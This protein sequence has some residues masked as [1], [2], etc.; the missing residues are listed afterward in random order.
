[1]RE[2]ILTEDIIDKCKE[3]ENYAREEIHNRLDMSIDLDLDFCIADRVFWWFVDN[4]DI[5][6]DPDIDD[7]YNVVKVKYLNKLD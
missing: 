7:I 3:F 1:M 6:E 2:E 5:Y 4:S